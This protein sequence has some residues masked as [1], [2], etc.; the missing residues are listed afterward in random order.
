MSGRGV[1]VLP[2]LCS[3]SFRGL[4]TDAVIEATVG[5][6]LA[7]I[8]WGSD[9]HVPAGDTT[10]AAAVAAR[11]TDVGLA[12]PSYGTYVGVAADGP[13]VESICETAIALGARNLRVWSPFG[14]TTGS[15]DPEKRQVI[16]DLRSTADVAAIHGLR[17]GVEFHG[18]TLTENADGAT[19]LV[20]AVGRENFYTYWQPVYWDEAVNPDHAAQL[21]SFRGVV[22]HVSHLHVYW[23]IGHDRYPL[24]DGS[25]TWAPVFDE[26]RVAGRWDSDR[27]AFLEYV[28]GDDV[29]LLAGEAA[30]LRQL[31]GGG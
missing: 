17:V 7:G 14:V 13:P 2:G 22:Q 18:Q 11:C 24:I 9:V 8:E 10:T 25:S 30:T 21:E 12:C 27:Y 28:P 1:D 16:D 19:R 31:L 23:W 4:S 15:G 6:G 26:A 20:E 29:E 5:A 3:I